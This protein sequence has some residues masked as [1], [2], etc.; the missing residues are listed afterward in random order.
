MS[1]CRLNMS[2]GEAQMVVR[3]FSLTAVSLML[4][5]S[6]AQSGVEQVADINSEVTG[7]FTISDQRLLD[8]EPVIL[9]TTIGEG[10]QTRS[11]PCQSAL[12][13]Y[14]AYQNKTGSIHSLMSG[15]FTTLGKTEV[16]LPVAVQKQLIFSDVPLVVKV[17]CASSL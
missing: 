11:C 17:E 3:K 10:D 9:S 14:S 6:C 1:F 8:H 4:F 12:F 15:Y 13:R 2:Q 5:S 16:L 7:C